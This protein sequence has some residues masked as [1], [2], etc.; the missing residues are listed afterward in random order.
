[1]GRILII[2]VSQR[3]LS[4]KF[5]CIFQWEINGF[6]SINR[7]TAVRESI[8][9]PHDDIT[10]VYHLIFC[11]LTSQQWC[12]YGTKDSST[13]WF[14]TVPSERQAKGAVCWSSQ[15]V[16][17][18][19]KAKCSGHGVRGELNSLPWESFLWSHL[20]IGNITFS[21]WLLPNPFVKA[22]DLGLTLETSA[23]KLFTMANL[24][25]QLSW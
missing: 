2:S 19:G 14:Q 25:Y 15:W 20:L 1:M 18:S 22:R 17:E 21:D 4:F 16:S 23:L 8:E 7:F 10:I 6:L 13:W 24:R 11:D 12:S 9:P 5:Q 3:C